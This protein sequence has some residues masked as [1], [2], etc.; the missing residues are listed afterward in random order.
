MG[1][2]Q[3]T[4]SLT[5]SSLPRSA[6]P[7][8]RAGAVDWI[9]PQPSAVGTTHPCG[10]SSPQPGTH[11][12]DQ[13]PAHCRGDILAKPPGSP[14]GDRALDRGTL[15]L[16]GPAWSSGALKA[17]GPGGRQESL[18]SPVCPVDMWAEPQKTRDP[19]LEDT[20][21]VHQRSPGVPVLRGWKRDVSCALNAPEPLS[22]NYH[23]RHRGARPSLMPQR[24]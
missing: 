14:V 3:L 6:L 21:Q 2:G 15:H 4:V 20:Y 11:P 7:P 9:R 17:G 23:E 24:P 5:P 12:Q 22:S 10:G 19:T 18:T 1:L 13:R 8:D 16:P